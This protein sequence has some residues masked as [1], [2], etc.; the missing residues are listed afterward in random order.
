MLLVLYD[1]LCVVCGQVC[2]DGCVDV[3]MVV[4]DYGYVVVKVMGCVGIS[5]FM[6]FQ[7]MK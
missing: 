4:G 2:V 6:Y 7:C 5:Y 3:V 1:Y